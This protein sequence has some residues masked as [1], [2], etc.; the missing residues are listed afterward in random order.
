MIGAD[1][2]RT[3]L[4]SLLLTLSLWSIPRA[5]AAA[6]VHVDQGSGLDTND[7][8]DWSQPLLTIVRA[9]EI[10]VLSPEAD[11]IH[12]AEGLYRER[13]EIGMSGVTLLGG[14]PAGGGT[15]DPAAHET[16]IEGN[17]EWAAVVVSGMGGSLL[18]ADITID[19]FTLARGSSWE[20]SLSIFG[21]GGLFVEEAAVV[22]TNNVI[23]DS[24]IT[25]GAKGGGLYVFRK[26]AQGSLIADNVISGNVA[27]DAIGGGVAI[28]DL[29]DPATVD[30]IVFERNQVIDNRAVALTDIDD[31]VDDEANGQGG[32]LWNWGGATIIADNVFRGNV[33]EEANDQDFQGQG[34][35]LF[36]LNAEPVITGNLIENNRSIGLAGAFTGSGGGMYVLST[37]VDTLAGATID[38]NTLRGNSSQGGLGS[39]EGTG[40]GIL[41][42][43]FGPGSPLISNN[44][45]EGNA[46]LGNG[47]SSAR[48]GGL[49]AYLGEGYPST[50]HVTGGR[51]VGNQA[52]SSGGG[53]WLTAFDRDDALVENI[54]IEDNESDMASGMM[55]FGN[56]T[57]RHA[58]IRGNRLY[59]P[60]GDEVSEI[61]DN[62]QGLEN[63]IQADADEDGLGDACDPDDD[64]DGIDDSADNCPLVFNTDQMDVC[65]GDA[66]GDGIAD[67]GDNCPLVANA[68]Q[69]DSDVPPNGV[70]DACEPA[71]FDPLETNA[72]GLWI[73]G[74]GEFANL[75]I[76]RNVGQGL[77]IIGFPEDMAGGFPEDPSSPVLTNLTISENV[78]SGFITYL[79]DGTVMENTIIALNVLTDGFDTELANG[80]PSS[81]NITCNSVYFGDGLDSL[82]CMGVGN[83]DSGPALDQPPRFVSGP[84]GDFYLEQVAAGGANDSIAVDA[85]TLPA[86]GSVVDGRTTRTDGVADAGTVDLGYHYT[87]AA[88]AVEDCS[89]GVDD[90]G[91]G[92]VDCVSGNEDADT[93]STTTAT[94]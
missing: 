50:L 70:G 41:I 59:D 94:V 19:G 36:V 12:V 76:T 48:G 92:T 66:D 56:P 14:Y 15:R 75:E 31:V 64:D 10:A 13:V 2:T 83:L 52:E 43:L 46:A 17:R 21:G 81:P 74:D 58:T 49:Y 33:A 29:A 73:V 8:S 7:G 67:G 30:P 86:A 71:R 62:C 80:N 4:A 87:D 90:D 28:I 85:G 22:I 16:V 26:R 18:L 5:V 68:D 78:A 11:T 54:A 82:P 27:E 88:I 51:V 38:G 9:L 47:N 77:Q 72:S 6:D 55:A 60:D 40:G 93:A 32:G 44:L 35:G 57:L 42:S 24:V 1:M 79:A 89:N 3:L 25:G 37:S 63:P 84:Q 23:R 20:R 91:D 69:L 34:G 53:I 65:T 45:L 39:W 61:R